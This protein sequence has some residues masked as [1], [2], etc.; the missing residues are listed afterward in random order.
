MSPWLRRRPSP[1]MV[2]AVVALIV[3]FSGSAV[4]GEVVRIAK[5]SLPGNRLK[6]RSVSGNRIKRNTLTGA[7]I[8]E[9]RLGKVPL[10]GRADIV[11]KADS[12]T[13]AN[14]AL[15]ANKVN[16]VNFA[17][18]DY[19]A[20]ASDPAQAILSQAGLT[21]TANCAGGQLSLTA[22]TDALVGLTS[23]AVTGTETTTPATVGGGDDTDFHRGDS[24]DVVA[25]LGA[26]DGDEV[27]GHLIYKSDAGIVSADLW[28]D[29]TAGTCRVFGVA[30]APAP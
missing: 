21:L 28:P 23:I 24:F 14:V 7:E 9:S 15:S 4:A 13:I 29:E 8:A 27:L 30:R 3:G 5:N 11:T 12:A 17:Q 25:A 18:I 16:G 19:V 22:T 10:A 26:G 20:A 2:V 6:E 1:A